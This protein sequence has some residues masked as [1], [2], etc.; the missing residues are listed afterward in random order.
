M[1]NQAFDLIRAK[2]VEPFHP[3]D[4]EWKPQAVTKDGAKAMAIAYADPRAYMNRLDDVCG[5]DW[6]VTYTPWGDRIVCHLTIMGIT[7]SSTGEGDAQ[8]ERSEIAGT[9]AEGQAFK[10]ACVMFGLGRYL[11]NL[12]SSWVEFDKDSK[13][14]TPQGKAKL[15]GLIVQHYR[16]A[17]GEAQS[18][19][20]RTP[21]PETN[22][23]DAEI[24]AILPTETATVR[25]VE[26]GWEARWKTFDAVGLELYGPQWSQVARHNAERI[27]DGRETDPKR[28]TVA[29]LD[30][31]IL[32]MRQL[33]AKRQ[34]A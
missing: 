33:K 19:T 8:S 32:G 13:Q 17:I 10:R 3:S 4:I 7:R 1:S 21:E 9:A 24:A 28:L 16:R 6:S 27:S 15:E 29:Q 23:L 20:S 30:K 34:P 14:F 2:L 22:K 31:M 25:E 11:Y 18:K 26:P 5:G 12:P